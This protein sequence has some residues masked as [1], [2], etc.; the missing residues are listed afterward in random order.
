MQKVTFSDG[1]KVSNAKVT[2]DGV[3]YPVTPARYNGTTPLSST[4]MNTMQDNIEDA[5]DQNVN[6]I[7]GKEYDNTA[8]Y[9]VGDIVKYQGQLYICTTAITTAEAWNSNHWQATDVL[10]S[11]GGNEIAIGTSSDITGKTKIF[12]E[13]STQRLKYKDSTTGQ[14]ED[15]AGDEVFIG[16]EEDAPDSTKLLVDTEDDSWNNIGTEVVDTLSGNEANRA[17]SVRAVKQKATTSQD[18]LMSKE[19]KTKLDKIEL[20]ETIESSSSL[21][22]ND[23]FQIPSEFLNARMVLIRFNRY[24][25]AGTLL[26]DTKGIK[27]YN[28][29]NGCIIWRGTESYWR[30][31][32]SSSGLITYTGTNDENFEP[33]IAVTPIY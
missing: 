31:K 28:F 5:I 10:S 16:D 15:I 29:G 6:N 9:D 27:E 26:A 24:A 8:T 20:T 33:Y 1:I 7:G 12:V 25:Q 3:D 17:P 23:T 21:A 4:V 32:I 22:V 18:G 2:I 30:F 11:A 13:E 19:D 14:F